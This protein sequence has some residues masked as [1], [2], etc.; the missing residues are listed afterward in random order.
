M[1][2]SERGK[3][4]FVRVSG[5]TGERRGGG[6][7]VKKMGVVVFARC[8]VRTAASQV[9]IRLHYSACSAS[10]LSTAV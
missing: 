10:Q 7:G 8:Q 4:R 1:S 6:V 9:E 2:T 5:V 3:V